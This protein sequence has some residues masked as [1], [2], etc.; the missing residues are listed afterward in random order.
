MPILVYTVHLKNALRDV[1]SN[2]FDSHLRLLVAC[3]ESVVPPP[4]AAGERGCPFHHG[5]TDQACDVKI[6][7]ATPEPSTHGPAAVTRVYLLPISEPLGQVPP[8][9]ARPIAIQH[10]LHE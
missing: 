1:E 10:R 9:N 2:Y 4:R 7:L 8:G 3:R 6:L 5:C